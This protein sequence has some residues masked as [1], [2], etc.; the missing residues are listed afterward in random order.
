MQSHI[1][2]WR[3]TVVLISR[4]P[5]MAGDAIVILVTWWK[6]YKLKKAADEARV[7]ISLVDLLLRDGVY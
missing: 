6:T 1:S 2:P 5:L 3:S 4:V 7:T